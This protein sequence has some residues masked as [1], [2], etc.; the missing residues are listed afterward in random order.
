M[1][2]LFAATIC[3]IVT[4]ISPTATNADAE[5]CQTAL[6]QFNSSQTAVATLVTPYSDC[7]ADSNGRDGC[8]SSFAKLQSAQSAFEAAVSDYQRDCG[9]N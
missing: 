7:I 8:Q 4:I 9:S 5:A 6:N 3:G 1:K 2:A